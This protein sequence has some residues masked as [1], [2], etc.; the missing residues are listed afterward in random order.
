MSSNDTALF[1]V[2]DEERPVAS[3]ISLSLRP[4]FN[5]GIPDRYDFIF[6][7]PTISEWRTLPEPETR[8]FNFST[9][10]KNISFFLCFIPSLRQL[11][12]FV[13]AIGGF[14]V[15]AELFKEESE[16]KKE[17]VKNEL[18]TL[19]KAHSTLNR[20]LAEERAKL[21]RIETSK[22]KEFNAKAAQL[23]KKIDGIGDILEE[24]TTAFKAAAEQ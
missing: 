3:N 4:N 11:T 2:D 1:F 18:K 16:A 12:A 21:D 17:E 9:T 19:L 22:K 13:K 23:F 20:G 14:G 6:I 7:A 8:I 5:S 10:S 24:Y 15:E